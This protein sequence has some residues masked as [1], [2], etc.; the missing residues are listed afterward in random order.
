M[1]DEYS[2]N[3]ILRIINCQLVAINVRASS[4]VTIASVSTNGTG[5]LM[6]SVRVPGALR[7][8]PL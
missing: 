4:R 5:S 7:A 1:D 6:A 3:D 2:F 8:F